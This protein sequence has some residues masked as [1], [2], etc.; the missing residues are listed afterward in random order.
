MPYKRPGSPF[1]QVRKRK[2]PG[3]GDT[4]VLVT[5]VR[6]KK[7]A[8][9]MEA[10]LESIAALALSE[11]RYMRLLEAVRDRQLTLPDLYA[12]HAQHR[13]GAL[14]Q[15]MTD[16]LLSDACEEAR[17]GADRQT[18]YGL[19]RLKEYF[20]KKARC[21]ALLDARAIEQC[22][23][24]IEATG[25]PDGTSIHRN[26]V[27]RQAY[28]AAGRVLAQQYGRTERN[29]IMQDVHF[30]AVSDTREVYMS[31]S[32]IS[33]LLTACYQV[34]P[35]LRTIVLTALLTGADRGVLL[36]GDTMD[37]FRRGLL[38]GDVAV[39]QEDAA[40]GSVSYCA[41]ISLLHDTKASARKRTVACGDRLARELLL[42]VRGRKDDEPVFETT[43]SQLD[44]LWQRARKKARLEHVRFKDLRA[45]FAVFAEEAG[46]PASVVSRSMGHNDETMTQ[47]YRR[48][49]R[50]LTNDQVQ[51]LE[52]AMLA[53]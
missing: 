10:A 46:L 24:S 45:Q 31:R 7:A 27:R 21:S 19:D 22:L 35:E 26:T 13:L 51:A 1:Y 49:R 9:K 43:W 2:L 41:E 3:F 14:A 33:D 53:A 5:G 44:G 18:G 39:F 29:R 40:D 4:G 6:D 15:Q 30:P 25:G 16:V 38:C 50:S 20:G 34:K 8:E 42:L 28:R 11:P 12:A 37:G 23:R 48:T 36:R 52:D 32:E 47:R 17:R